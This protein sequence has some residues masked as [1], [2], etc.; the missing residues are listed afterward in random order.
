MPTKPLILLG[1]GGHCKSVIDVAESAGYTILGILDKPE[2]VETKVLDYKIIGTDDDI[3]QYV[4]TAEFMITVGQIK[5]P[6][7]RQKLVSLVM[8]A[9]GKFA[10]II[11]RDAYVSNYATIGAGTV[12]MHKAVVN[13][14]AHIGEHCIINTM[15]NI[16]HEVQVGGFC[17]ISTGVMVNGNCVIGNE[18]FIGSG[19]V[20]Y[21][22]IA[23]LDNAVIPAGSIVRK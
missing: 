12:I 17:H 2:L 6:A 23:V 16:E 21:N 7:I 14:D 4:D 10:T 13:A 18:V 20:L 9:G 15:A 11:A 19:S 3:P 8:R 5:S 22:G 1:G